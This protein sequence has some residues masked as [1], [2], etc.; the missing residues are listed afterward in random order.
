MVRKACLILRRYSFLGFIDTL[1]IDWTSGYMNSNSHW[2]HTVALFTGYVNI[3]LRHWIILSRSPHCSKQVP[4]FDANLWLRRASSRGSRTP[5]VWSLTSRTS[6]P[7]LRRRSSATA[8]MSGSSRASDGCI[9]GVRGQAI[10]V[11]PASRLVM[12]HTAA[13]KQFRDPGGA[14]ATALWQSLVHKLSG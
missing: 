3:V 2:M 1:L 7:A 13:R 11:D 6:G 14:E 12:V 10:F 8:I 5:R 4:V 9:L